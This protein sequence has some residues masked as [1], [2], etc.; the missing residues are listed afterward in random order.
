MESVQKEEK[1]PSSRQAFV[2]S[3]SKCTF[4]A[5]E[6]QNYLGRHSQTS[7][8]CIMKFRKGWRGIF[9]SSGETGTEV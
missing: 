3:L 5:F 6:C 9:N 1:F 7:K 8:I 2:V 4:R